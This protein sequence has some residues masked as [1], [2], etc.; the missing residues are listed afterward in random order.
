MGY[1]VVSTWKRAGLYLT[2][3]MIAINHTSC[4]TL[5]ERETATFRVFFPL[6]VNLKPGSFWPRLG[7]MLRLRF[8]L[9]LWLL[10]VISSLEP[11]VAVGGRGPGGCLVRRRRLH[12]RRAVWDRSPWS[13]LGTVDLPHRVRV[14]KD[15]V[16]CVE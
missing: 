3:R 5:A 10:C 4:S 12:A 11:I 15:F 6:R 1:R 16:V 7:L 2:I 9:R 8:R 13:G 14:I